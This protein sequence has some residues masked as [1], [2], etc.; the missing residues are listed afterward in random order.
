MHNLQLSQNLFPHSSL[1][2]HVD[3]LLSANRPVFRYLLGHN[4]LCR[5]MHYFTD[6]PTIARTQALNSLKILLTYIKFKFHSKLQC[7]H[8]LA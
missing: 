8:L 7:S 5:D 3:H 4:G 6:S 2:L 1:L